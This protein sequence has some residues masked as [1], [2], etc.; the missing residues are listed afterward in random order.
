[1][2]LRQQDTPPDVNSAGVAGFMGIRGVGR[3]TAEAI[4]AFRRRNG[5]FRNAADLMRVDGVSDVLAARIATDMQFGTED[6]Y[7]HSDHSGLT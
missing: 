2:A 1:V 7:L 6:R 4:V 5:P 3:R